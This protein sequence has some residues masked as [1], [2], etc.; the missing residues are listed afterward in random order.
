MESRVT[1]FERAG[2]LGD[3]DPC[4]QFGTGVIA[5]AAALDS[6][7]DSQTSSNGS[8]PGAP[9]TGDVANA[10]HLKG[11]AGACPTFRRRFTLASPWPRPGGA[12]PLGAIGLRV[13][14]TMSTVAPTVAM[15]ATTAKMILVHGSTAAAAPRP[16]TSRVR[17][18]QYASGRGW[19]AT[20]SSQVILEAS[21]GQNSLNVG[22]PRSPHNVMSKTSR[23]FLKWLDGHALRSNVNC[24]KGAPQKS[25]RGRFCRRS[26]G[27]PP[28]GQNQVRICSPTGSHS[29]ANVPPPWLLKPGPKEFGGPLW[30]Q[31]WFDCW[32]WAAT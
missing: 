9:P 16:Y 26:A 2:A 15:T 21:T 25:G 31:P 5:S 29:A 11:T 8:S 6:K 12:R 24:E 3:G 17:T 7:P 4:R 18:D 27:S 23:M 10:L 28:A 32:P 22:F 13:C 20:R 14:R 19:A 1:T 30:E